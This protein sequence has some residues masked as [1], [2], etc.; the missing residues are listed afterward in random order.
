MP[1]FITPD[2]TNHGLAA[3]HDGRLDIIKLDAVFPVLHGKDGED[4]TIQ[5][6]LQLAGIP[7]VGAGVLSSAI[8]MDKSTANLVFD[9]MALPHTPWLAVNRDEMDD[10]EQILGNITQKMAFPLFVKPAEAGSSIG[11][12]KVDNAED[13]RTAMQIA[14]AHGRKIIIEQAVF[15]Q[16]VECAVL[17][18]QSVYSTMPGEIQSCNEIYDYQAKYQSGDESK[19]F[20][21]AHLSAEKQKE[22]QA[23]ALRAYKALG[24]QGMARVDFFV[25]KDT[26]RVLLSEI[27]TIPGFTSIS[28]YPKLMEHEGIC[29]TELVDKLIDCAMERAE[30]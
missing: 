7:Y 30:E 6:L 27:N 5:G 26:G 3:N 2:R 4:G 21:P 13:L 16:E 10:F 15:G 25:E 12:T 22:V 18:N 20:I 8:C 24:C 17:G 29:F 14:S 19:L 23:M 1:A 11:V 28:M 9:A